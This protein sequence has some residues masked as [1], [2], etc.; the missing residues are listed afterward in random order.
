[1]DG[2]E[3]HHPP[4]KLKSKVTVDENSSS[5]EDIEKRAAMS[6]EGLQEQFL[7]T[8]IKNAEV[9]KRTWTVIN[10][11]KKD[12]GRQATICQRSTEI[13]NTAKTLGFELIGE[14]ATTICEVTDEKINV[15][16]LNMDLIS[17]HIDALNWTATHNINDAEDPKAIALRAALAGAKNKV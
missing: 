4:N 11:G 2:Y 10:S 9:M 6:L 15:A 1:M 8:V 5:I 12:A 16:D 7:D 13:R 14:I 3:I 17:V